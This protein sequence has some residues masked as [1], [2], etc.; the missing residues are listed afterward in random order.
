MAGAE[1][2]NEL[3]KDILGRWVVVT[4]VRKNRPHEHSQLHKPAKSTPPE[5]CF[6]CPGNEHL[7]PPEIDRV[8]TGSGWEVRAFP[9]KFPA[10]D[11]LS[12]KAYGRHEIIV[13]TPNHQSTLSE[14]SE[15][16]LLHYLQMLKRRMQDAQKDPRLKYTI[17]FKNEGQ[18]AGASLEHSHTQLVSMEIIPPSI[19]KLSKKTAKFSKL[20][21]KKKLIIAQNSHFYAIC[22]KASRFHGEIWILPVQMAPSLIS[23]D[24]SKLASLSSLLKTVL[25]ASDEANNFAPYN[26]VFHS[27]AHH[28]D[29]FP[30]HLQ[31]LPRTAHWAGFELGAEV[32]MVSSIPAQSAKQ[33]RETIEGKK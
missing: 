21:L 12:S 5:K 33:L 11:S 32:Y 30:F 14:L 25:A 24:D 1:M 7:T 9:N 26:I 31:I 16:N 6:F 23:L 10:F 28:Q 4:S 27:S 13:E 2:K 17:I 22:P 20:Y 8:A 18:A 19:V 29:A 3:Q 15:E